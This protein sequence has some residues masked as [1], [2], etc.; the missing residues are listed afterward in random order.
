MK[1]LNDFIRVCPD[2]LDKNLC[3]YLC[4]LFE[5]SKGKEK[6]NNE[7]IKF[8]QVNLNVH[9]NHILS[10]L[11]GPT[12]EALSRYRSKLKDETLWF[13]K[14]TFALEEFRV[15]CYNAGTGE[16]FK[17]HVD[18]GNHN[19]AKR[20]LAFLFYLNDD[21]EGGETVFAGERTVKPKRGSVL[22]FPP[23]WQYPH[24]GLP[25]KTGSKFIMSTYL[26]Y[27]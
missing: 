4:L 2:V 6:I 15:K 20:F 19:S 10:R 24:A 26:H 27:T 25:V 18:V 8:T 12:Q 13:P 16:Q 7:V 22:I 14:N 11:I 5:T 3:E 23:T 1:R 9:H 17:T 21:F